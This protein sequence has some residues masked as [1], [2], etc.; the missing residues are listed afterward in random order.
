M[1]LCVTDSLSKASLMKYK[2]TGNSAGKEG[3]EHKMSCTYKY[4]STGSITLCA[5][6]IEVHQRLNGTENTGELY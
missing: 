6:L 5:V 4:T 3:I 1:M 2:L